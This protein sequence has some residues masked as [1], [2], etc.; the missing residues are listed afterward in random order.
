MD[1]ISSLFEY[2][3]GALTDAIHYM[4]YYSHDM[5]YSILFFPETVFDQY[6]IFMAL[7]LM[8]LILF[9]QQKRE[10]KNEIS[11]RKS[12]EEASNRNKSNLENALALS[13]A[14]LE[15]TADG[16]LVLDK[17]SKI[18]GFNKKFIKMWNIPEEIVKPGNEDQAVKFVL[19][20]V[21]DPEEF[22]RNIEKLSTISPNAEI[23]GTIKFKDGRVFERYT[24]PQLR[25]GNV[26]GRVFSFRD[27]TKRREL[28][29]Q[30]IYQATH[31]SLTLLPKRIVLCDRISHAI[32]NSK[33]N[34]SIS[35]VLFCGLDRFKMVNDGLGHNIGDSLL[36]QVA[37]R[38]K[39]CVGKKD[40][41]SRVGGDEFVILLPSL[42]KEEEINLIA[43]KCIEE[44][45][46]IFDIKPYCLNITTSIGISQF[47]KDGKE[48]VELLKNAASALFYAKSE[49]RNKYKS[50]NKQMNEA[51]Q[52]KLELM[53]ELRH[54]MEKDELRL[55]YQPLIDLETGSIIGVEA[56]LRWF[57]TTRGPIPPQEF[58]S[59]A[60]ECGYIQTIG[61]WILETACKQNKE[62]QDAGL[63]P[64]YM[65]I[66]LSA[67]QFKKQN[68]VTLV[69][70]ILAKNQLDPKYV[71]LELT[72]SIIMEDTN[73]FIET[74]NQLKKLGVNL[75]I[76]DFGTGYSS[77]GYLKKFPVDKIKI[78]K[79][80]VSELPNNMDDA[81]IV[82]AILAM[83]KQLNLKVVAEGIETEE[84]LAFLQRNSCD[85]AQGFL[86]SKAVAPEELAR[87]LKKNRKNKSSNGS[88]AVR[89]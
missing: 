1:Q 7:M 87:L 25:N 31:D 16:I 4:Y 82:R 24:K 49:G 63:P 80:F 53:N 85:I 22:M 50:F 74:L 72:E 61:D 14:T 66:N 70:D 51:N 84:Q 68:V 15:A 23:I 38:L 57:H 69:K 5:F 81:A 71:E 33:R 36:K 37:E 67:P 46:K 13:R 45:N 30:L 89:A 27:V 65:S 62:W 11:F 2:I 64:I 44:L 52:N 43:T 73:L 21:E 75:V 32:T 10:Y 83:A 55:H 77:L 86:I 40:T 6:L 29:K 58:I 48:P 34:K 56:L 41:V 8:L 26:I 47:P 39:Q 76:D 19:N 79:S 35:A 18:I 20:Q 54:A 42:E 12:I 78:D 60:E 59:L 28:E 3:G 9:F 17:D 88:E